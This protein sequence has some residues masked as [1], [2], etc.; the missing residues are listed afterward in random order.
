VSQASSV[1]GQGGESGRPARYD[2][3]TRRE[4]AW[5][6]HDRSRARAH[7]SRLALVAAARPTSAPRSERGQSAA[8]PFVPGSTCPCSEAIP[9]PSRLRRAPRSD[10]RLVL[11]RR[12]P[13]LRP[14]DAPGPRRSVLVPLVT[15]PAA[16][17]PAAPSDR[18]VRVA[19]T[20]GRRPGSVA[21]DGRARASSRRFPAW[22]TVS[23]HV[24]RTHRGS[25]PRTAAE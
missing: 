9:S 14:D 13:L 4:E 25:G 12:S 2:R 17:R 5:R 15:A 10:E 21:Y 6:W 19:R 18:P 20:R 8:A 24:P 1:G 23:C 16:C 3:V 22:V 7:R 11:A